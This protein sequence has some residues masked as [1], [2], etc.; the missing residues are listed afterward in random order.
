MKFLLVLEFKVSFEN[1]Q[2]WTFCLQLP[3]FTKW[4]VWNPINSIKLIKLLL[5]DLQLFIKCTHF[6]LEVVVVSPWSCYLQC[7]QLWLVINFVFLVMMQALFVLH[8]F[9]IADEL[10]HILKYLI[11]LKVY[12][13]LFFVKFGDLCFKGLN[14]KLHLSNVILNFE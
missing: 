10:L 9:H 11:C 2:L 8:R 14:S 6:K 13:S 3:L 5:L 4:F 1:N 7:K 12:G